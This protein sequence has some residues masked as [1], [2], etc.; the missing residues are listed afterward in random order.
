MLKS[1]SEIARSIVEGNPTEERLEAAEAAIEDYF[2][3]TWVVVE[4]TGDQPFEGLRASFDGVEYRIPPGGKRQ[5]PL[6]AAVHFL[7]NWAASGAQRRAEYQRLCAR[8]GYFETLSS[9]DIEVFIRRSQALSQAVGAKVLPA[10][11]RNQL[12]RMTER[13]PQSGELPQLRVIDP[14]TGEEFP[15]RWP[16]Y[17]PEWEPEVSDI[18]QELRPVYDALLQKLEEQQVAAKRRFVEEF[19]ATVG[20]IDDLDDDEQ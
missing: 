16:L 18:P 19:E 13:L 8:Y 2:T 12:K 9:H 15:V 1:A 7:G 6:A 17:D 10:N 4:N 20:T 3:N 5:V 11:I 14:E